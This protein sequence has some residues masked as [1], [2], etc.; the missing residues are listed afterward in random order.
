MNP[1]ESGSGRG[2]EKADT[3]DQLLHSLNCEDGSLCSDN[4]RKNPSNKETV[5]E[6]EAA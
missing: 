5:R 2:T 4:V 3:L 6:E 1:C